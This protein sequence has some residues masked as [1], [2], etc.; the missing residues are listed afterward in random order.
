MQT[1][2]MLCRPCFTKQ[3]LTLA[4]VRY[5]ERTSTP[6]S[7]RCTVQQAVKSTF[8]LTP[9]EFSNQ[10]QQIT[11]SYGKL[12]FDRNAKAEKP[13]EELK[14]E[15]PKNEDTQPTEA[16]E[17]QTE[18]ENSEEPQPEELQAEEEA[19]RKAEEKA[20]RK[21]EIDA[22]NAQNQ[23]RAEKL[24]R[25][26]QEAKDEKTF[27]Y[28]AAALYKVEGFEADMRD[29]YNGVKSGEIANA[30]A[31]SFYTKALLK[32]ESE[33]HEQTAPETVKPEANEQQTEKGERTNAPAKKS[34]PKNEESVPKNEESVPKNKESVPKKEVLP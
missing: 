4:C 9:T 29:I 8:Q 34:V 11:D 16:N 15:E 10:A 23:E 5:S 12:I 19:K 6:C 27:F 7:T 28:A 26:A 25:M 18:N 14:A 22:R 17:Q 2:Q 33:A 24:F 13:T 21:A 20:K 32:T 3:W 1:R 30:R 31:L